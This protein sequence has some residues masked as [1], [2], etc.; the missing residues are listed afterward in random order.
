MMFGKSDRTVRP[1]MHCSACLHVH[2]GCII[3]KGRYGPL[4]E[5]SGDVHAHWSPLPSLKRHL[6]RDRKAWL[7]RMPRSK[8]KRDPIRVVLEFDP[9]EMARRGRLGGLTTH[10]RHDSREI[11][12]NARAALQ[13]RF[14]REVDPDLSLPIDER[15]RRAQ[16]ARKL[17]Y[18]RIGQMSG[19]SRRAQREEVDPI[20]A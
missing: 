17:Y 14:V 10:S 1:A 12:K 5:R 20:A 11:T 19:K 15:E 18:T 3:S 6:G 8:F 13:D 9:D 7:F 4:T 2:E 16:I